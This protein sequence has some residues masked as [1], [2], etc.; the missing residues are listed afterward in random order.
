MISV[1]VD[2]AETHASRLL[3]RDTPS[4]KVVPPTCCPI[5]ESPR[6]LR[7]APS[8]ELFDIL[9][10]RIDYAQSTAK[11]TR[12]LT[13]LIALRPVNAIIFWGLSQ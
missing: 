10:T 4:T 9:S 11:A 12:K 5:D 2:G 8:A 13:S 1:S 7:L 6:G 3:E